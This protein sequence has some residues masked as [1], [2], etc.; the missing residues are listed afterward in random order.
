ME[1]LSEMREFGHRCGSL[2]GCRG[3]D[4]G[5]SLVEALVAIAVLAVMTGI[6]L[7][8]FLPI[9]R[10]A[11]TSKTVHHAR[12]LVALAEQAAATGNKEITAADSREAIIDLLERGVAGSGAFANA[13]FRSYK[14]SPAERES[15]LP[16]LSVVDGRLTMVA[17]QPE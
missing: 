14:L 4:L 2:T 12:Q 7:P 13:I 11:S 8:Q 10:A 16:L 5:F 15:V 3:R 17:A 6:V 1:I 9:A